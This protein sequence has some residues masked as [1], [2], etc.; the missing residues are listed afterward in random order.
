M[1]S[2]PEPVCNLELQ[3]ISIVN[4]KRLGL[5]LGNVC[6]SLGFELAEVESRAWGRTMNLTEVA[7]HYELR[8]YTSATAEV[9]TVSIV[10]AWAVLVMLDELEWACMPLEFTSKLA[11]G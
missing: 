6:W 1:L 3:E 10:F 7:G 9:V 5:T 11:E 8:N 4:T 2:G